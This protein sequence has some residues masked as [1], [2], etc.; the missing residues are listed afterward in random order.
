MP[1]VPSNEERLHVPCTTNRCYFIWHTQPWLTYSL[2]GVSFIPNPDLSSLWTVT[3]P[4][5]RYNLQSQGL[6]L[7]PRVFLTKAKEGSTSSRGH[8][9]LADGETICCLARRI[10]DAVC[11]VEFPLSL[12]LLLSIVEYGVSYCSRFKLVPV[13]A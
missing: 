10:Q 4:S 11:N 6:E 7:E 9:R 1:L 12:L 2:P 3:Q 5:S 13:I 8:R